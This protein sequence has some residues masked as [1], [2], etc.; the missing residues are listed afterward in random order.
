MISG[1]EMSIATK[2][3][4]AKQRTWTVPGMFFGN[5]LANWID[6]AGSM[7]RRLVVVEFNQL[8][9]DGNPNMF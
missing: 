5:E 4:D 8:V 7:S 9:K 2:F 6:A 1:E 3:K